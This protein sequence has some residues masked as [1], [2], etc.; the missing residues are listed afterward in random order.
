MYTVKESIILIIHL[1]MQCSPALRDLKRVI[2]C[3]VVWTISE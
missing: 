2:F 1:F 3:V